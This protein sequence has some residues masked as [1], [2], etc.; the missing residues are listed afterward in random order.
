MLYDEIPILLNVSITNIYISHSGNRIRIVFVSPK[1][2]DHP[3]EKWKN[4]NVTSIELSFSAIS[5]LA[6]ESDGNDYHGDINITK[7]EKGLL[8]IS[9]KGTLGLTAIAETGNVQRVEGYVMSFPI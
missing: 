1:H 8:E 6:M 5:S 4:S 7:N 9:I 3:P 2:A